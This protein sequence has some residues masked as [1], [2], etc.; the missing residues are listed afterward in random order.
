MDA[1]EEVAELVEK[2]SEEV[3]KVADDIGDHLPEGKLRR[4]AMAVEDLADRT[5]KAAALADDLIEKVTI[6]L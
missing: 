3:E 2:V 5:G 1:A 4:A 6:N